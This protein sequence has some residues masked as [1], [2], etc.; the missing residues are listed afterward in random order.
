M[1]RGSKMKSAVGLPICAVLAWGCQQ[2]TDS[3][4]VSG[5]G[6]HDADVAALDGPAKAESED[7][8]HDGAADAGQ[9]VAADAGKIEA[10]G[11]SFDGS[12]AVGALHFE[13]AAVSLAWPKG[14]AL[15]QLVLEKPAP[16][17]GVTIL[18]EPTTPSVATP[19]KVTVPEGRLSV[20]VRIRASGKEATTFG[21]KLQGGGPVL[22][23][24]AVTIADSVP[25]PK[26]GD[27]VINEVNYDVRVGGDDVNCDGTIDPY[28]DEFIELTNRSSHPVSLEGVNIWN[29]SRF[30]TNTPLYQVDSSVPLGPGE[31]WIL[32]GGSM[33][34]EHSAPWCKVDSGFILSI[35]DAAGLVLGGFIGFRFVDAGDTVRITSSEAPSSTS[36]V[37][38]VVLPPGSGESWTRYPDFVGPFVKHTSV[39]GHAADRHSS[40][41]TL[42]TGEPFAAVQP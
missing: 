38:P 21:A 27:L 23:T 8:G 19:G 37:D 1:H 9:E 32:L 22:A 10:A 3:G 41:G 40:P 31:T 11:G 25:A 34:T 6:R 13:P 16:A 4:A 17:G 29:D 7:A 15:L 42:V 12:V 30:K 39:P 14:S 26:P 28:G 2:G 18:F 35:G 5:G 36:L 20:G 24:A 33:G